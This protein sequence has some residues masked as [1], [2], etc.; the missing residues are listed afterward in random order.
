ME[1]ETPSHRLLGC[2]AMA[3]PHRFPDG[4]AEQW[5]RRPHR[6]LLHRI[7]LQRPRLPLLPQTARLLPQTAPAPCCVAH[8]SVCYPS[9]C[10]WRRAIQSVRWQI[11]AHSGC[12]RRRRRPT[13]FACRAKKQ[14]KYDDGGRMRIP[15]DF[16]K[17]SHF[18]DYRRPQGTALVCRRRTCRRRRRAPQQKQL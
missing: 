1:R 4:D 9:L 11:K 6:V 7:Q 15:R 17:G 18:K 5:R 16:G 13:L 10:V 12:L 14:I 2:A 8:P 3:T